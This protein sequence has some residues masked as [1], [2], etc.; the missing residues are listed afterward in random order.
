MRGNGEGEKRGSGE[1]ERGGNGLN[2]LRHFRPF[3]PF[4]LFPSQ[5]RR[6][7]ARQAVPLRSFPKGFFQNHGGHCPVNLTLRLK[8]NGLN[9]FKW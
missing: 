9:N 3:L 4:P 7:R 2:S 6:L 5:V 1:A 8:E